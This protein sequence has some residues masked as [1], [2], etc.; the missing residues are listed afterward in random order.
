MAGCGR[1]PKV[2]PPPYY[3]K[4]EKNLMTRRPTEE[5]EVSF[6][7]ARGRF[8]I[9][10]MKAK[11]GTDAYNLSLGLQSMADGLINLS[12]G[13]RATYILL[14]QLQSGGSQPG[15]GGMFQAGRR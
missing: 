15:P 11:P 4:V 13:L 10:F 7:A 3:F 14:E 2:P 8:A 6:H 5:A 1:P 9:E 12:I